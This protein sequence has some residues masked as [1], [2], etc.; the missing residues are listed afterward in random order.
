MAISFTADSAS[1]S[2]SEYYLAADSTSKSLQTDDCILQTW[3][4]AASIAAGDVFEIK[5]YE[6]INTNETSRVI[7]YLTIDQTSY[8]IPSTIVGEG[9]DVSVKK[10]AGTD[11][12]IHWSLR[13]IT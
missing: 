8:I 9:W 4:F 7:G 3:I 6:K 2:S 5:L 1:I 12:T 10:T 11:R 13:K